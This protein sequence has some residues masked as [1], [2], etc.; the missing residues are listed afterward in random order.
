MVGN[1]DFKINASEIVEMIIH[2]PR[3]NVADSPAPLSGRE[4]F[5]T[6]PGQN[7]GNNYILL[8]IGYTLTF[9]EHVIIIL[10]Q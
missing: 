3:F 6:N 1:S 2:K 4:H 8:L 5:E 7:T 10:L 9:D